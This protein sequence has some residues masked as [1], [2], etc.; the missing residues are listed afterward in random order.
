M[1]QIHQQRV[2]TDIELTLGRLKD[3]ALHFGRLTVEVRGIAH[4]PQQDK[5][6][7]AQWPRQDKSNPP[8]GDD[9]TEPRRL[10]RSF[11]LRMF[12]AYW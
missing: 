10:R 1:Q 8:F 5:R 11:Q 4:W 3:P 9:N 7:I 2:D 6:G 12:R